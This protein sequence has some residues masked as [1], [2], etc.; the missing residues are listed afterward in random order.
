MCS[1]AKKSSAAPDPVKTPVV[2]ATTPSETTPSTSPAPSDD[3]DL[4]GNPGL[5]DDPGADTGESISER[6]K[7]MAQ[8]FFP[9]EG[10]MHQTYYS[11]EAPENN[12]PP[13]S[14]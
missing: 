8:E 11:Y 9:L 1:C 3:P 7:K 5:T 6:I 13:Y 4:T 14:Y 2:T 10:P 12:T